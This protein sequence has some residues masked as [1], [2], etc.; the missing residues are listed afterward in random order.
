MPINYNDEA[1]IAYLKW[2]AAEDADEEKMIRTVR[3]YAS[4]RQPSYLTDRQKEFLGLKARNTK[5]LYAHNLCQLVI[6]SV[7]ER[8]RIEEFR[9]ADTDNPSEAITALIKGWCASNRLDALLD[10]VHEAA[11]RDGRAYLLVDWNGQRPRWTINLVFDGTQGIRMIRDASTDGALFAVKT[12]QVN[13]ILNPVNNGSTRK[14]LYF[15]DR[16]EKYI[17][18]SDSNP[19]IAGTRWA[20]YIDAD[21]EPW[22]IP[23][24]DAQGQPLGIAAIEFPNPGGSE[25]EQLLPL[26]DMLNKSDLDVIAASDASGFRIL[27]VTGAQP[28]LKTDGAEE[29]E[30]IGPAKL[31]RLTDPNAK[32]GAIDASDPTSI[33]ASSKYWI[34]SLAGI[35]RTPQYLFQALGADQPSGES[36]KEQE[37]G[38]LHK[39]QRRQTVFGNAWEDVLYLSARLQT[40]YRPQ[41]AA[42]IGIVDTIWASAEEFVDDI[43]IQQVEAA[44]QKTAAE[45]AILRQQLGVSQ[46]QILRE[47]G[48]TDEQIVQMEQEREAGTAQL[49]E[50]LLQAFER[51]Q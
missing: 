24:V 5:Y 43:A 9:P 21:G 30:T 19:G 39:V 29:S 27:Y 10:D 8:L 51:G 25:I 16:V 4:G 38:L 11:C 41:D 49:G 36:L 14:T 40:L 50:T 17:S 47:L 34:E 37:V 48:Y 6:D 1:R 28:K 2:L 26:Q 46:A 18:A 31:M 12:W 22:P 15:P 44:A 3:D 13:D 45:A 42:D 33:I 20:P 7:V 32:L 23:W 35:S